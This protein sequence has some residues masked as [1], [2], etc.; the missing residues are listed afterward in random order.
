MCPFKRRGYRTL[1]QDCG[2]W[3]DMWGTKLEP[4][5]KSRTKKEGR[6]KWPQYLALFKKLN[7]TKAMDDFGVTFLTCSALSKYKT[8]NVFDYYRTP[9]VC[10]YGRDYSSLFFEYAEKYAKGGD[11]SDQPF[12]SYTHLY[13]A[14]ELTG[15]R[16][17]NDDVYLASFFHKVARIKNTFTIFA[18]DHGIKDGAYSS[19]T[20]HGRHEVRLLTRTCMP[21]YLLMCGRGF[22]AVLHTLSNYEY[23]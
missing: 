16:I 1:F 19:L 3:Y 2:C 10:Y 17:V 4:R 13:T 7:T 21:R 12:I 15:R 23:L 5:R 20:D 9:N 6:L 14:H 11:L 18:S 8:T 22:G